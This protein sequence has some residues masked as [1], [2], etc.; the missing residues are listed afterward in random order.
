MTT[1]LS[2][3]AHLLV[4]VCFQKENLPLPN[5]TCS[6]DHPPSRYNVNS[7]SEDV[8]SK[9]IQKFEYEGGEKVDMVLIVELTSVGS[10]KTQEEIPEKHLLLLY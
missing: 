9:E 1:E 2:K 8:E 6:Q 4:Q 5:K 3:W 10:S 7:H